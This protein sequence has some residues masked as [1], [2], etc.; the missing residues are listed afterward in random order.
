MIQPIAHGGALVAARRR[1]PAAPEP[2]LDLSTGINPVPY[3][4]PPLPAA[5]F[6]RL[7]DPEDVAALEAVAALAYG[8]GDPACVVAAPGTQML[9][10][11]LPRLFP[12]GA[13]CVP[14]PTYAEHQAVWQA[15][16][17]PPASWGTNA[18]GTITVVCNPN[19]P[20]G[21][22]YN[23]AELLA[24]AG[25]LVVDEAFADFEDNSLAGELPRPGLLLLRSFG[26][27][28]GLAGVRLGFALADPPLAGTIRA[29]LGPWAVSGPALHIGRIALADHAWRAAAAARLAQDAAAMDV[30]L[31]S[32]GC[33][34]V[35]GTRLF[36]L[37]SHPQAAALA[38][39]LGAAGILVRRF[40]EHP[41]W[42]RF[43]IAGAA[44]LAR[45]SARLSAPPQRKSRVGTLIVEN[46]PSGT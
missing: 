6:T 7:P 37:V 1:F 44:A 40:D 28:Y 12:D 32:A 4:V 27:A 35:G 25:V 39:H 34:L 18:P 8:V 23:P 45:L 33:T 3:P 29:V 17:R 2:W 9:I 42:L 19:N 36:R 5:A 14:G 26:K 30:V 22:R 43:G 46:R 16:C 11:M 41:H 20:D 21:R 13:V 38:D 24:L 31:Q 15:A 10:Q